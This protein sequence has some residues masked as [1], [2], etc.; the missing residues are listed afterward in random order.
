METQ[1]TG[2]RVTRPSVAAL[3]LAIFCAVLLHER[4]YDDFERQRVRVARGE[5]FST[6]GTVAVPLP[7]L[8]GLAG[9]PAALILRLANEGPTTRVARV[10]I[11]GAILGDVSLAPGRET[12]ADLAVPDGGALSDAA[13]T[14]TSDGDGWSLAYIEVA[15]IHG[16]SGAPIELVVTPAAARPTDRPG[17]LPALVLFL[18]LL[19]LPGIPGGVIGH[20]LARRAH[21]AVAS[22]FL[23]FLVTVLIAPWVSDFAVLLAARTFVLCLAVL[24]FPM[25]RV[26]VMSV[27]R[28]VASTRTLRRVSGQVWAHR[29][30]VLYVASAGLF[31]S[32]IAQ[33]YEPETGLTVLIR[34]GEA[35]E[36]RVLPSVRAVPHFVEP[37]S[38]GYDGQFYAQLAVDPFLRD[39]A[40]GEA[41][42]SP[43]YRARRILFS[44]TAYVLG[45]GQPRWVLQAYAAQ[46]VLVWLVLGWLLCRWFPPRDLRNLGLWFGCM[47][48]HG[49]VISVITAVPDGPSMLL[50][51]L[52]VIAIERGR[53]RGAAGLVGLA[54]LAKDINLLW[55]AVLIVPDGLKRYGLRDLCVWGVLLGGPV[56]V[57]ML[58]LLAGSH[59][60]GSFAGV[61]NFGAPLTGYVEKWSVTV[62]E[63]R[64]GGWD[65]FAR[66]NLLAL[67]AFTTQAVVLVAVRDW[68]NPWWRAGVGSVVLMM[69]LGP[70][71][72]E[73]YPG[74]VTRVLLPMV[75]AFNAVLPR[76]RWFWPLFV[77]GNLSVLPA[78]EALRVPFWYYI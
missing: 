11:G 32:S 31:I 46:N 23:L 28:T 21:L 55:S 37:D 44:W 22:L 61:R 24:Y 48:S 9:Q 36:D 35:F 33:W 42:D 1:Y 77:L 40:I 75:F 12:R 6:L 25:L 66:F 29:I 50:L 58:Y 78:L 17:V 73:G 59:E 72:W 14:V 56:S 7:D 70:A 49:V 20:R 47:F 51:A 3:T 34:F 57:W 18:V 64:D 13:V 60:F 16:F 71:V 67:I 38:A 4:V 62:A 45:L 68:R 69:F 2:S 41:L 8:S 53:A 27:I 15:N 65:T 54:G 52:S 43:A 5:Q 30:L 19:L 76:T 63:L 74:A 10:A 39:P 26:I